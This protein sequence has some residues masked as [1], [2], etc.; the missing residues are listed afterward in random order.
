MVNI[1]LEEGVYEKWLPIYNVVYCLYFCLCMIAIGVACYLSFVK[2]VL[3]RDIK[4][5]FK[6]FLAADFFQSLLST[7]LSLS[8]MNVVGEEEWKQFNECILI[9]PIFHVTVGNVKL[10]LVLF[11]AFHFNSNQATKCRKSN[12]RI[13][14]LMLQVWMIAFFCFTPQVFITDLTQEHQKCSKSDYDVIL[15]MR[16][17]FWITMLCFQ[18]LLFV[19]A[20][21]N[22]WRLRINGSKVD[23]D[24]TSS[25]NNPNSVPVN[26]TSNECVDENN[27]TGK[28]VTRHKQVSFEDSD[29]KSYRVKNG[30]LAPEPYF[31]SR[32]RSRTLSFRTYDSFGGSS[33]PMGS[34]RTMSSWQSLNGGN[35]RIEIEDHA[36]FSYVDVPLLN[37]G[38]LPKDT[39]NTSFVLLLILLTH[40][41]CLLPIH[42]LFVDMYYINE[43]SLTFYFHYTQMAI[44]ATTV[45]CIVNPCIYVI[46]TKKLQ[47]HVD[48]WYHAGDVQ[49]SSRHQRQKKISLQTL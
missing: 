20:C 19:A 1:T 25:D 7:S 35:V 42:T 3:Q 24:T 27:T 41:G 43:K 45:P 13:W 46:F 23:S 26:Q 21:Y 2:G 36:D 10:L 49:G 31:D 11:T 28:H 12:I 30:L 39:K 32:Q 4:I 16:R 15:K 38:L 5:V 6:S 34:S 37:N 33:A 9:Y 44:L 29:N 18:I 48:V 22:L 40:V 14:F 17:Q 8:Q 47:Y